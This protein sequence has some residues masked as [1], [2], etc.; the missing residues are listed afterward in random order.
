MIDTLNKRLKHYFYKAILER[1]IEA[2]EVSRY[3]F[4]LKKRQFVDH[5]FSNI[6]LIWL[7][8]LALRNLSA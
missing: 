8:Q 4:F 1:A 7:S 6:L 2:T 5:A 3:I